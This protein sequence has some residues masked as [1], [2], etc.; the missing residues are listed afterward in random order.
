MPQDRP[1]LILDERSFEGLLLAAFTI[2]EHNDRRSRAE[3]S[4]RQNVASSVCPHCGAAK[5]TQG[6]RCGACGQDEFRPGERLQR[7]WASMWSER[8]NQNQ[9]DAKNEPSLFTASAPAASAPTPA[10]TKSAFA[11]PDT[12]SDMAETTSDEEIERALPQAY[13]VAYLADHL[14]ADHLAD[15]LTEAQSGAPSPEYAR[16]DDY[17]AMGKSEAP[18]NGDGVTAESEELD[19]AELHS[20]ELYSAELHSA[21][22][23]SEELHA[24]E[25]YSDELH[26]AELRPKN[27]GLV[28]SAF[29]FDP[30]PG[31]DLARKFDFD[32]EPEPEP[33]IDGG[34]IASLLKHVSD[35][36]VRL[37]FRRAD[38][39]LG[40]AVFVAIVALLWPPAVPRRPSSLSTWERAL[41]MTG[42]AEAPEAVVHLQGDPGVSVW[43]DP[44]T[45]L[46]YCDGDEQYQHTPDGRLS[47]QHD[48]QMDRFEPAGRMACE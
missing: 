35:L 13:R 30:E 46:Y 19:S 44:H 6:S 24:A 37:R 23:Y 7:N 45:A 36:R 25:L 3:A 4:H 22:L 12:A 28:H 41:V 31:E 34:P 26:A 33:E 32:L 5:S 14:L 11:L 27:T 47:S 10:R 21:H 1:N 39:Y 38:L 17:A 40:V 9:F 2:Q 43:V 48:A 29:R 18:A 15:H 8:Q 42:I 20:A 16:E